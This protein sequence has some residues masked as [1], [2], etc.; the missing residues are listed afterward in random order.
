[1]RTL[2]SARFPLT[3]GGYIAHIGVAGIPALSLLGFALIEYVGGGK[4][5]L[6]ILDAY[7]TKRNSIYHLILTKDSKKYGYFQEN[8]SLIRIEFGVSNLFFFILGVP[9]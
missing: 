7:G 4:E 1:L 8:Q 2:H 3:R 6:I 5:C 9:Q